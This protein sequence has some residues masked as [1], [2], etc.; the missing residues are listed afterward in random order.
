MIMK[1]VVLKN[2]CKAE[3]LKVSE[4]DIPQVKDDWV[5]VKVIGFGINRSEVILRDYEADEDYIN[6]PVIP[7]IECVGEIVDE[8]NTDFSKGD[9]IVALMG[10][11]GRSFDGSYAEYALLPKKNVFK[12]PDEAFNQ[13]T[14]EE[15]IAVPETYF[16]SYGSI[17]TL[18]L[19]K[20][21]TLLI[22]G[23]T[24]ATGLTVMQLASAIGCRIIA[25][26]RDE[27][28]FEKLKK[29]GA[30]ECVV[31]NGDLSSQISCNKVLELIGPKTL[32]D[33]LNLLEEDGICCVTGVL[34]GIEYLNDFDPIK[35]LYNKYLTSFFSNFPT[36]K[37][38][39]EIFDFIIENDIK[40]A[41]GKV[42]TSLEDIPKA[43]LLME[44]NNAQGKIIF[45][46]I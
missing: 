12:I 6:L 33:S 5:L 37:I 46:L 10:G 16:T 1:A 42:F 36:Q 39:D 21:D 31:D 7:G 22:R 44:S 8:S 26:S 35:Y 41:I 4:V 19:T 25:T 17:S 15:I 32:A 13:L 40:P 3:D 29:Y 20:E 14:I 23:A 45:R 38:I 2:T 43:H 27:K 28:R 9:K 11:M 34:G 24:S 18:N 30:D